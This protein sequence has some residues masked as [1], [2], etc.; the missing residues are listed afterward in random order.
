MAARPKALGFGKHVRL[1]FLGLGSHAWC[2]T[3]PGYIWHQT[4]LLDPRLLSLAL[5][6]NQGNFGLAWLAYPRCLSL[7]THVRSKQTTNKQKI[8]QYILIILQR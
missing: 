5:L 6:P 8:K 4:W 1:D 2:H 3:V 7:A